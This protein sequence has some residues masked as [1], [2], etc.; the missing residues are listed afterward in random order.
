[1]KNGINNYQ[2]F[3]VNEFG[4]IAMNTQTGEVV[5]VTTGGRYN[6]FNFKNTT[7]NAHTLVAHA[8]LADSYEDGLEVDHLNG[9]DDNHYLSLEWVSHSTNCQRAA[10]RRKAEGK[11]KRTKSSMNYEIFIDV[12]KTKLEL[13]LS[14]G[15]MVEYVSKTHNELFDISYFSLLFNK[16]TAKKFWEYLTT[17]SVNNHLYLKF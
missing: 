10:D 15:Q 7:I 1:M 9:K 17:D 6:T 16:A 5:Q 14:H 13:N 8:W 3:S 11:V 2:N 4:T 12:L